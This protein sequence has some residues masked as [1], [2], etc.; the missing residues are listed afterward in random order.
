MARRVGVLQGHIS[1]LEGSDPKI[2]ISLALEIEKQTR[3]EVPLEVW[4][5]F[6]ALK[7]RGRDLPQIQG[8]DE[9]CNHDE[10]AGAA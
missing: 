5:Q 7:S 3:G 9:F 2:S 4:P 10:S 1:K 6:A 8:D